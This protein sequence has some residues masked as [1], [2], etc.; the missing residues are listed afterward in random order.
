MELLG[1]IKQLEQTSAPCS[2][3]NEEVEDN[4]S[5]FKSMLIKV[6]NLNPDNQLLF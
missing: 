1:A 6:K 2:D 4:V 3:T 5:F